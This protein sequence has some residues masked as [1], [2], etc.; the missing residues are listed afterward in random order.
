MT[1]LN[2]TFPKSIPD[3]MKDPDNMLIIVLILI[4]MKQKSN[5]ALIIALL[6]ILMQE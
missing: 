6:S 5:K 4:L 2:L 3:L 1:G